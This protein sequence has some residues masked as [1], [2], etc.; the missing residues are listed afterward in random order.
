[1]SF[2]E[3]QNR[4]RLY[5]LGALDSDE[6][7]EFELARK[8]FGQKAEDFIGECYALHEAFALSLK[9]ARSSSAQKE[10]LMSMVRDKKKA[11][12]AASPSPPFNSRRI[13]SCRK[14]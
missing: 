5:V 14:P 1:M 9:P 12:P 10:R 6:L 13:N 7:E 3:F 4:S 11:Y 2:E 8:D